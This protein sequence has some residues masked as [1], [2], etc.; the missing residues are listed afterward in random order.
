[1]GATLGGLIMEKRTPTNFTADRSNDASR[2]VHDSK[3]KSNAGGLQLERLKIAFSIPPT[4]DLNSP[5]TPVCYGKTMLQ[6]AHESG[7]ERASICRRMVELREAN[8]IFALGKALCPISNA[9]AMF[10]TTSP[11]MALNYFV[12]R[13]QSLWEQLPT[14]LQVDAIKAIKEYVVESTEPFMMPDAL[15]YCFKKN[16]VLTILE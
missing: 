12:S 1:M 15:P 6:V 8:L 5:A 3:G 14:D 16:L 4:K 9:R 11:Q 7:I 13:T 10:Y 2:I